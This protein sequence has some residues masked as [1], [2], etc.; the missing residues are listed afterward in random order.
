MSVGTELSPS[1]SV[2]RSV[3]RYVYTEGVL[4]QNGR[5]NLDAV[6]G[7]EWGR[8]RNGCIRWGPHPLR[9]KGNIGVFRPIGLNGVFECILYLTHV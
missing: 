1:P 9:E 6:R 2:G 7:G 8:S 4:W 5:L 3:G